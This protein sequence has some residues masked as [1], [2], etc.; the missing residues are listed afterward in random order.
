VCGTLSSVNDMVLLNEMNCDDLTM[1]SPGDI[2]CCE[3]LYESDPIM[4]LN[5]PI[6]AENCDHVCQTCQGFLKKDTIP[7]ESLANSFWIGS[8]PLVLQ[9]LTFAEKM[10]ISRIWHNK[11]LVRVSSGHPKMTANVMMFSNPTVKVYHAL[12]PSWCE[13][14]EI[15]AFVFQ[16]PV[17]LSKFDIK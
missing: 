7:P 2:G 1:I 8:I 4:S 9:N 12:P 14:G 11:C 16:G 13:I 15:L 10:L 17:Q 6:L 3:R 5:G